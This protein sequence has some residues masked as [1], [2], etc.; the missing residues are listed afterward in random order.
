MSLLAESPPLV[1]RRAGTVSS[2]VGLE[3]AIKLFFGGNALV[4]LVVLA[5]ITIFLAREGFG[6]FGQ[7]LENLRL[8]RQAG[9]E[10]VDLMRAETQKH[11]ALS[12][13]LSEVRLR[14]FRAA[15]KSGA[16][17]EEAN[18]SLAEFDQFATA[19]SDSGTELNGVVSDAGDQASALKEQPENRAAGLP[20]LLAAT[21]LFQTASSATAAAIG[22]L[23]ATA[24]TMPDAGAQRAL[25]TWKNDALSYASELPKTTERLR[26]WS[27]D[28]PVPW[29]RSISSF[30]FGRDWITASFWQDWYGI[31]PLLVGSIMVSLVALL[32]AVPLGV[33]SAIYVSEIA[34][35]TEKRLIKPYI[36]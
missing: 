35:K 17:L 23:A 12:R 36:E 3:K 20:A 19:F 14:Q 34:T 16:S 7:N 24:P 30:L 11:A 13:G 10:Y 32:L 27:A 2:R 21:P 4:A 33:S 1:P 25:A 5:L 8:Y 15:V 28:V 26:A 31:R 18:A 29:H 6:F 22:Q 9:L